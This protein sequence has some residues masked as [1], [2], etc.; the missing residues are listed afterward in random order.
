[1]ES[2]HVS[3]KWQLEGSVGRT[4]WWGW[5]WVGK[6]VWGGFYHKNQLVGSYFLLVDVNS[7]GVHC[8]L[9]HQLEHKL[10]VNAVGGA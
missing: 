5:H 4:V 8:K 10:G 6:K 7:F 3:E 9:L 2:T 1:M